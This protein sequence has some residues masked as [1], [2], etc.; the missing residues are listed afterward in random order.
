MMR[1]VHIL[2]KKA[3]LPITVIL[4][5]IFGAV[6][7]NILLSTS[8]NGRVSSGKAEGSSE[9]ILAS[10][11][12]LEAYDVGQAIPDEKKVVFLT[13][14]DE[15][16]LNSK[17][18]NQDP[19][20]KFPPKE[21]NEEHWGGSGSK[22]EFP[23]IVQAVEV[24]NPSPNVVMASHAD[25]RAPIHWENVDDGRADMGGFRKFSR[26]VPESRIVHFDLKGAAPKVNYLKSIM[27]LA[28]KHG[29]TGVLMEWE[30]M[31]PFSG[32]LANLTRAGNH[33][34]EKEVEELLDHAKSLGLDI[35]PL[36]Q[37]FGHMEF[38]LKNYEFREQR[39]IL[40]NP[41]AICPSKP[42][43]IDLVKMMIDQTMALHVRYGIKFLHIGCDEVFHLGECELCRLVQ[44]SSPT[45]N[46]GIKADEIRRQSKNSMKFSC[47]QD[48]HIRS[49][50]KCY[51]YS[52]REKSREALFL[53]HLR[54]VGRYVRD[55]YGV[56]PIV[57]DDMLRQYSASALMEYD[58]GNIVEPMV[59][60]Y[61]E[62]IY[63]FVSPSV[64]DTFAE[65]FP[66]VWAASAFKGAFGETL[67][68]PPMKRHV[69][70]NV[71]WLDVISREQGKFKQGFRLRVPLVLIFQGLVLTGWQRYD[72]FA[73]LCEILPTAI[74]SLL[75]NLLIVT[76]GG[77]DWPRQEKRF[78]DALECHLGDTTH[79]SNTFDWDNDP[80][81]LRLVSMCSF[82]G[83]K[84]LRVA[85][86]YLM[87]LE[88][89][90]TK[91]TELKAKGW[92]TDYNVRHRFTSPSRID[93]FS[94]EFNMLRSEVN[95]LM[96]DAEKE[97]SP[98]FDNATVIEWI[99]Q[100]L[101]PM[102]KEL[103]EISEMSKAV[104]GAE[105]W[106]RRPLPADPTLLSLLNGLKG[107][108]P[109]TDRGSDA[110]KNA[111]EPRF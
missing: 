39:E 49:R 79:T 22:R 87:T 60:V 50:N 64:F 58:L 78:R 29:A 10:R 42:S 66:T 83:S 102:A 11:R 61:A 19:A 43:S 101:Y 56:I 59:W 76:D 14:R 17:E 51:V 104:A 2:R 71:N 96:N 46:L 40:K 34:S 16:E 74:P 7:F 41:Q 9:Q 26:T 88:S 86:R 82:P 23:R 32:R 5:L 52:Y 57:W 4:C 27:S 98:I 55:T 65:V 36:V 31:L 109:K 95:F 100:K 110:N 68:V 108:S 20:V 13:R 21:V 38:A 97:L 81:M 33:Y 90:K 107:G 89:Y 69:D 84:F 3:R 6:T 15:F 106:P 37:T 24:R 111:D 91:V 44:K 54:V 18:F 72:H 77:F 25:R 70:N 48:A 73:V 1:F 62:D 99:E 92:F 93:E 47:N 105:S 28:R 80:N 67:V 53:G 103:L 8:V 35:I 85:K 94:W 75:L 45:M 63:R 12:Q 30:D